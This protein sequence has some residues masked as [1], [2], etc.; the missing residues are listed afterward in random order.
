METLSTT[1][2]TSYGNNQ[3]G[4][5]QYKCMDGF[6]IEKYTENLSVEACPNKKQHFLILCRGHY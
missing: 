1:N 5:L 4:K 6:E 3:L 2:L